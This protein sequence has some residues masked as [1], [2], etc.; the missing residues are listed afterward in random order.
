MR[1]SD[2]DDFGFITRYFLVD[3]SAGFGNLLYTL[4]KW[5]FGKLDKKCL[6]VRLFRRFRNKCSLD[7]KNFIRNL[8]CEHFV[9]E[10]LPSC[11]S[12]IGTCW[13]GGGVGSRTGSGSG[14]GAFGF[15]NCA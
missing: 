2:L 12:Q 7:F 13:V 5:V 11:S 6:I 3:D 8:K 9:R 4:N 15:A 1:I 14:S 10:S